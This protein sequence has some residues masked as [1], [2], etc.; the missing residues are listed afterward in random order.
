MQW[1]PWGEVGMAADERVS[2]RMASLGIVLIRP[3]YGLC[4]MEHAMQAPMG[5]V[6]GLIVMQWQPGAPDYLSEVAPR[7][8]PAR[9]QAAAKAQPARTQPT[10]AQPAGRKAAAGKSAAVVEQA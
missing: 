3:V 2:A 10:R 4:V 1:G 5:S 7:A 6:V 8:Q 9:A